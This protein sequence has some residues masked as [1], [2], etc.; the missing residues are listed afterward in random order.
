MALEAEK[1]RKIS[2]W[3][4]RWKGQDLPLEMC[5][6]LHPEFANLCCGRGMRLL[7]RSLQSLKS[8]NARVIC[9]RS[10]GRAFVRVPWR[11]EEYERRRRSKI[12]RS[13][14]TLSQHNDSSIYAL[15]TA[16]GRA[17]IAI[18]R[19][20]GPACLTVYQSLCPSKPPPKPRYASLRTLYAP[21]EVG[22]E[23]QVLDSGALVLYFPSP[24]T[25]T[26]EDVLEL[27]VHGGTAVVKAVL[28]SIPNA[29]SK[30][31]PHTIRYAEPGEFTRRAF[32]NNRLDLLQIEELGDTL[33]AETEQ[34]RRLAV[35]GTHNVLAE[36]Y[37]LWRQKLLEARGELEALID[38]SED[39][40]FDESPAFLCDSVA[41]QVQELNSQLQ[42]NIVNASR[43][44]LLRNGIRIALVG[45]PNAG[46][47]SLL[48]EIVGRQAAIVSSEPGT[49]RDVIEVSLDIGGFYCTIADLAG[50]RQG[51]DGSSAWQIGEI[52]KE[53]MRR[54]KEIALAAD[55]VIAVFPLEEEEGPG[56]EGLS[57]QVEPV[58][59]SQVL[60]VLQQCDLQRQN[61]VFV[62]NK[63]DLA[64]KNWLTV[65]RSFR[66][67]TPVRDIASFEPIV[68]AV[69]CKNA[70]DE[71]SGIPDPGQ[72]QAFMNKL[73]HL[74]G[75]MTS[76]VNIDGQ[77]VASDNSV[78][79]ESLGATERQRTLLEHCLQHLDKFLAVVQP[80]QS[81]HAQAFHTDDSIDVV[82]AAEHLRAAADCLAKI[83]GRGEAGDVEEV[84]GVV[85]EK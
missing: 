46:K 82:V 39:Q 36:R 80:T 15:S 47:S 54:A 44:E 51:A 11:N 17:A 32:Y 53:G 74:F 2:S 64:T 19:V 59:D 70:K 42:L 84:L 35:R 13:T 41:D 6:N 12:R 1:A 7:C 8:A 52:E 33:A 14:S 78:W 16:P 69:S 28:S 65:C 85:F 63:A 75:Q 23:P 61:I 66:R 24:E 68:F 10:T 38:F 43:G 3:Q 18:I 9:A 5:M 73:I 30:N 57:R 50:L 40:D 79:A 45:A 55:V 25:V 81:V 21:G 71:S 29:V 77:R 58:L 22:S 60:E 62:I 34:Q 26:G 48:N 37:E 56:N 67:Q 27:H 20:S 4:C 49:T 72:I 31:S 76:A 83:T